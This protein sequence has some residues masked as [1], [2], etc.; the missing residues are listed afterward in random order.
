M[1]PLMIIKK[2][3]VTSTSKVLESKCIA[4]IHVEELLLPRARVLPEN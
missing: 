4:K 2:D 1:F 3:G